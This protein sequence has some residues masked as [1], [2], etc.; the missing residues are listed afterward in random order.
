MART[1]KTDSSKRSDSTAN[2]SAWFAEPGKN[3]DV[4]IST[5]A[6]LAR[7]LADFPFSSKMT[8]DDRV[9]NIRMVRKLS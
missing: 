8:D 9:K 7:N 4:V 2:A 1:Q 6:R 3:D 5:R